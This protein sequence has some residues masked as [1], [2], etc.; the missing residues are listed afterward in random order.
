M[1]GVKRN[2]EILAECIAALNRDNKNSD[3]ARDIERKLA[4][5]RRILK[6]GK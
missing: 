3:A 2:L 4:A 6:E 1:E 5:A